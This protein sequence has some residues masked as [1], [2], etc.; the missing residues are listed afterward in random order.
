MILYYL[1]FTREI[2]MKREKLKLELIVKARTADIEKKS[3]E[4]ELQ[5]M[6]RK[7]REESFR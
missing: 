4:I 1:I 2:R 3:I 6:D 7:R 5:N